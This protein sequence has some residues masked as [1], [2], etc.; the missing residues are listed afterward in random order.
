MSNVQWN[1]HEVKHISIQVGN[2]YAPT[3]YV[4]TVFPQKLGLKMFLICS[5]IIE[6]NVNFLS[7]YVFSTQLKQEIMSQ[8]FPKPI[9]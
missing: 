1:T 4:V 6:G 3:K 9:S 8:I 5:I 7:I 2:L